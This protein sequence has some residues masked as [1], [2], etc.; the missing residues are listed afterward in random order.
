MREARAQNPLDLGEYAVL[1]PALQ[2]RPRRILVNSPSR[3]DAMT[4]APDFGNWWES[5]VRFASVS[6][7]KYHMTGRKIE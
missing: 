3:D 7:L 4:A 1:H 2:N 6:L 5:S